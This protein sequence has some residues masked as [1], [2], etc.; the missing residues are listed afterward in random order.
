M[1]VP[2]GT[3]DLEDWAM[4]NPLDLDWELGATGVAAIVGTTVAE[5]IPSAISTAILDC[6]ELEMNI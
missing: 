1:T 2:T 3:T 6:Q 5:V 4:S